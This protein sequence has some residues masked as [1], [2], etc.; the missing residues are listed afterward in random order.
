MKLARGVVTQHMKTFGETTE[1][2]TQVTFKPDGEIFKEGTDFDY[3]TLKVRMREL[4]FLNKGLTITLTDVRD[5]ATHQD[6]FCYAG[7]IV[8]FIKFLNEGKDLVD[9]GVISFEGEKDRVIVDIAM[10]YQAGYSESMYTFVNNINTVEGGMHLTGFRNAL[11]RTINDYA[12]SNNLL[13]PNE[14]N[15]SGDDL[16]EGLTA[17]V[18]IKIP[19]PQFEGQTK[20]KLGNAEARTAVEGLVT[21]KLTYFLEQN[22][23]VAKAIVGKAVVA[24]RARMAARKARDVAR[25]STLETNM[26]LPGKLADCSD[27]NPKNCE[28]YIVEGDSAGGS[29]K[30]ARS[31]ATQAILPLRGKILNVEKARIDRILEN[32]EIKAM[33][34]AFGTGIREN[35]NIEKLR[36]DKIIIMTDADVDGAHIATLMLTFFF[37]FMPDLIKEGHVYLA[38]P[39]LYKLE[40]NKKTWYAYSDEELADIL[41]EVGRDQ[42]NKIQRYK[43]LGEMDAEQLW[44]TTMD[45]EKRVLLRVA[46]DENS[47]SELDLT[48]DT[49]MGERVEPR[50]EFIETNA[51][52]VK[53]LDI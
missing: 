27:P 22:P 7:G 38:Q 46:I 50:R 30:T 48:F 26:A 9:P 39:P 45:P 5:G 19:E 47:E 43:G 42:N 14:E 44:D 21:E 28:I 29:A 31:R 53:N 51:K 10:Q 40:K 6:V 18:S 4:A 23:Q 49:L 52:F 32:A 33:I 20:Q 37:R 3:D 13:K 24:Q 15:L 1:T 11:T 35:F 34:T 8:E 25:K 16:R 36:Y 41:N 2:G 17:I 12:R